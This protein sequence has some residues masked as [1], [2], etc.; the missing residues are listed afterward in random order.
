MLIY[1]NVFRNFIRSF[2]SKAAAVAAHLGDDRN[3]ALR[4]VVAR[5]HRT[6]AA[7]TRRTG[8]CAGADDGSLGGPLGVGYNAATVV[9]I[10]SAQ[11]K[12]AR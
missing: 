11:E 4:A 3:R 2:Y 5:A 7:R 10:R 8:T 6:S 12:D 9:Q 1:A